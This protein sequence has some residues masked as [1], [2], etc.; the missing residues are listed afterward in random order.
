VSLFILLFRGLQ[1]VDGF[2]ELPGAPGQQRSLRKVCRV[3]SWGLARSRE[4]PAVRGA[5]GILHRFVVR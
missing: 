4:R 2:D 1:D 3:F 5:V